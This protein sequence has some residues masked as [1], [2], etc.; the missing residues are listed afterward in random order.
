M[1]RETIIGI[2]II[3]IAAAGVY[4]IWGNA[5]DVPEESTD[6]QVLEYRNATY[7][8][9]FTYPTF[10]SIQEYTPEVVA[11]GNPT[12]GGFDAQAES[13]I[14][15]SGNEGG[16][17]DFNAFLFERGR[18]LCAADG[19]TESL[20]CTAIAERNEITTDTGLTATEI[21]FTLVRTNLETETETESRYG[22]VYAFNLGANVPDSD[23][24]ALLIYQPLA[25]ALVSPN[26]PVV[27]DIA[28]SVQIDRIERE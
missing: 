25:S 27:S 22:P 3:A 9:S 7:G 15:Q 28:N 17:E 8:Y 24:A 19:P 4:A 18:T 26:T 21:Y 10:V 6:P 23:F 1:K 16:Y 12:N 14:V 2:V 5:I 11:I 20:N 13:A